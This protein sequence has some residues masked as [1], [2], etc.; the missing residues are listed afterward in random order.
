[1]PNKLKVGDIVEHVHTPDC[2]RNGSIGVITRVEG[3]VAWMNWMVKTDMHQ[4]HAP[5]EYYCNLDCFSLKVL[6]HAD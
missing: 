4:Q 6:T 5:H 3:D 1:M 2:A